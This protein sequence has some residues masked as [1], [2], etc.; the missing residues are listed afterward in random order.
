MGTL[1][2]P[3]ASAAGRGELLGHSALNTKYELML[4]SLDA[5][6]PRKRRRSVSVSPDDAKTPATGS[7]LSKRIK[8]SR[9]R[10][11]SG[12]KVEVFKGSSNISSRASSM[13]GDEDDEDDDD[14][15]SRSGLAI[16]NDEKLEDDEDLDERAQGEEEDE[17][18][19]DMRDATDDDTGD[20]EDE[21]DDDDFLARDIEFG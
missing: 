6:G 14:D 5:R 12:L 13:D 8:L 9:G 21:D 3:A 1:A 4:N 2:M 11:Q 7:P 20:E 18:N 19:A 17:I 16:D 15:S 10:G